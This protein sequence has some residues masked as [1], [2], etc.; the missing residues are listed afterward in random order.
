VAIIVREKPS[1]RASAT[2]TRSPSS[3]SGISKLLVWLE[4]ALIFARQISALDFARRD[5]NFRAKREL[6]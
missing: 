2:S 4:Y 6:P 1:A 5:T 3:P